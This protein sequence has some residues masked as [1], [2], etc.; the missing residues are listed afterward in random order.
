M[1]DVFL[2]KLAL[3]FIVGGV[4]TTL[5]TIVAEKFGTKL[6]GII[7]GLPSTAIFSLFFIG[8]TQ[9]AI[10]A[11]QSTTIIPIIMGI[12]ALFVVIYVLLSKINFYLAIVTSLIFWFTLSL[13]LVFLGF[14]NF[15][16]SLIALAVLLAFSYFVLEKRVAIKSEGRKNTQYT[17][18]QILFRG[19]L[20]GIIIAFAVIMAEVG[21]P[22]LGGAFAVFPAVM[23][24]VMLITYFAQGYSF[25]WAILKIAAL[26]GAVNVV[27][28]ASAVRYTYLHTGLV[29]GTLISFIISLIS[30]SC[31]YLYVVKKMS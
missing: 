21:G 18:L 23:F 3:S 7:T 22:L 13:G 2:F 24:S 1:S 10:F 6:G 11:S 20:G 19:V 4:W 17:S 12:D 31:L 9:T 25:S 15:T 30:A 29:Y 8:W 14:N 5:A 27:I 28:Y 26:T 16:Y